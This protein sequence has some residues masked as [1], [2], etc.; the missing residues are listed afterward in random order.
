MAK[1]RVRKDLTE[2][3][4][5]WKPGRVPSVAECEA[6]LKEYLASGPVL[7][8]SR[9]VAIVCDFLSTELNRAG[10]EIDTDLVVAAALL[11]DIARAKSDHAVEAGRVLRK[12][13][14]MEVA[15]IVESHRDITL[16]PGESI[17]PP[18][19]LY[20]ADKL[21][22]EDRLV[23]LSDRFSQTVGRYPDKPEVIRKIEM[24]Y[25]NAFVIQDR[26]EARTGPVSALLRRGGIKVGD[27]LHNHV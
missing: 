10:L 17:G 11:H 12:H 25:I 16:A 14:Y 6:L 7:R 23:N 19:V 5:L 9:A 8:H 2:L 26:V 15:D 13:G 22:D 21:V 3:K 4:L 27:V 18:E 20:L 1:K 24:R